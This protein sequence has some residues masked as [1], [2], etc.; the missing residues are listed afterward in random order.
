MPC[1]VINASNAF[2][3]IKDFEY[4]SEEAAGA[5]ARALLAVQPTASGYTAKVLK[6]YT[7]A[8][9]VIAQEAGWTE[10]QE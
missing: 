6:R 7:T 3:P 10:S 2:D 5:A 8:V 1:F 4:G 9:T